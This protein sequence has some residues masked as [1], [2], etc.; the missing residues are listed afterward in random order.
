[1]KGAGLDIVF[2]G[3]YRSQSAWDEVMAANALRAVE[4]EGRKLVVLAGSGHVLYNLG[5]NRRAFSW[6]RLPYKT[7]VCVELPEGVQILPVSRTLADFVFGL[8]PE[9]APA[10]PEI[11]LSFKKVDGLENLV[12]DAKPASG[13]AAKADFD[14]GD[15][16][17]SVDGLPFDDVNEVRVHLA[18]LRP[19]DTA[20][21]R[22][23]RLAQVKDIALKIEPAPPAQTSQAGT[24]PDKTPGRS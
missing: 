10:F 1:M 19:G 8:A 7:V 2:E 9:A 13:A 21:F 6:S 4:R 23:L 11:G 17:L 22:V 3:L 5:I 12:L 20:A 24:P 14:K 15:V 18:R 16:V